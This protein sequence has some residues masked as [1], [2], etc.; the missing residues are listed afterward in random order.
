MKKL[1]KDPVY[2]ELLK[3][4]GPIA[5]HNLVIN[6]LSFID[7]FMIGRLGETEIAAVG[8][9]NQLF[10]LY[11]LVLFGI[12]SGCGVFVS[13]YWGKKDF[14]GIRRSAGLGVVFGLTAALPFL[15]LSLLIPVQITSIFSTDISV[16]TPGAEYLKIVSLS[17]IFSS[18]SIIFA[19]VQRS[20]EKPAVPLLVSLCALGI[21]TILNYLFI[22]GK[23]GFPA[24]GVK[25]VAIATVISRFIE[26]LLMISIVFFNRK[27]P[28]NGK[29]KD[30]ISFPEGFFPRFIRT[31]APVIINELFWSLGMTVYKAV[32]GRLGT[33]SLASVNIT[34]AI[35]NLM[36]VA[37]IGSGFGT[38]VITG[39][40]IGE[41][42]YDEARR[43]G[44]KFVKLAFIEG[45]IMAAVTLLLCRKLPSAFNVSQHVKDNASI[46]II[47]YA[48]L[49]PFKSF[50]IHTIV[51]VFRGGGDT[52][53]AACAEISGVWVVGVVLAL[54]TGLWLRMPVYFV[55]AFVNCEE[56]YK[57]LVG[58]W[59]MASGKWLHDVT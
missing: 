35:M 15:F 51:G 58:A 22:F 9:G 50:N 6:S 34:E 16:I 13:Q 52:L 47:I 53:F 26:C 49:L 57:F 36:F 4:A 42:K 54:I 23:A 43:N 17:Y 2:P 21:N 8:I 56:I 38:A 12:G 40:K 19:Q 31:T 11:S 45:L 25:G 29:L 20:I 46:L 27:N 37:L 44:A 39:K 33:D 30:F 55:F 7:T 1:I 10:F 28:L 18:V 14:N 5:L 48:A 32:Y 59:R 41:Q 3:I 24:W